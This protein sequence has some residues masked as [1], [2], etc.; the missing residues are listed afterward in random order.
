MEHNRKQKVL[1]IVALV[2]GIASLSLGFAAFSS[3]LNISSSASVTPNSTD[4]KIKIYGYSETTIENLFNI[5]AY[6]SETLSYGFDNNTG[7]LLDAVASI[8]NSALAI[9]GI[10]TQMTQPGDNHI[11][12]FKISNEGKYDAYFDLSQLTIDTPT[13]C[14]AEPDTTES[15]VEGACKY[16]TNSVALLT[17]EAFEAYNKFMNNEITM[18]ELEST[19]QDNIFNSGGSTGVYKLE[20]DKSVFL[21][22]NI[23]YDIFADRADGPF[24]VTFEDIKLEF[25]T[26]PPNYEQ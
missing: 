15:L 14:I 10:D 25:T 23:Y 3:T 20:K 18:E 16:I 6:T 8:N 7:K 17:E 21:F 13:A 2:L 24:T 22:Q 26:A 9:T 1:M 11:F 5:N 12:F 4:F 19:Q